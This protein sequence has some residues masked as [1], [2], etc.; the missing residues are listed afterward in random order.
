MPLVE[1]C[2]AMFLSLRELFSINITLFKIPTRL[3]LPIALYLW[4]TCL[5]NWLN[6]QQSAQ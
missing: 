5:W 6:I 4:P 3:W 2:C 1:E